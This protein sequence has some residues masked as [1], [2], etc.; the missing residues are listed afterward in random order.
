MIDTDGY[1]PN[2][3]IIITNRQGQLFWAKRIGE[4]AWQ[5]P[6]G[7]IQEGETAQQAMYRELREEVGLKPESIEI[8]AATKGWLRYRLPK[9][10]IRYHHKPKFVGQKQKWY[11]LEMLAEDAEVDLSQSKSAEFDQWRWVSYWYPLSGVVSFKRDVYR[12]ALKELI[13]PL[14][15]HIRQRQETI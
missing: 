1:R 13:R 8:I 5:F 6:Q 15:K 2:V 12:S 10:Y 11:L 4:D 14:E 7:G 9:K 3:G